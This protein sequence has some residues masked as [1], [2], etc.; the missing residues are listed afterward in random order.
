L[1]ALEKQ[2]EEEMKNLSIKIVD[3]Y[4]TSSLGSLE[5]F[6]TKSPLLKKREGKKGS[7]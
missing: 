3:N 2:L 5:N 1:D 7:K 4:K 6:T